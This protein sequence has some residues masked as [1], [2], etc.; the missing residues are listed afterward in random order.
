MCLGVP[1]LSTPWR[2][3]LGFPPSWFLRPVRGGARRARAR[4]RGWLMRL[5]R[6]SATV[7]LERKVREKRSDRHAVVGLGS[8]HQVYREWERRAVPAAPL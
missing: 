7:P 3:R 5:R 1:G 4:S 8:T 6:L 2:G